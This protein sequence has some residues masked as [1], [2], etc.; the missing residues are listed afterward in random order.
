MRGGIL[1]YVLL[2]LLPTDR[3]CMDGGQ[4][5]WASTASAK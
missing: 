4:A 1:R 5:G 2:L 3:T